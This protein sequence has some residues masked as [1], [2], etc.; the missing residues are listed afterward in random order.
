[1]IQENDL[2]EADFF[3]ALLLADFNR[4]IAELAEGEALKLAKTNAV[5]QYKFAKEKALTLL[6]KL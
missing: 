3:W 5:K 2:S 4:Y 1:M 6:E